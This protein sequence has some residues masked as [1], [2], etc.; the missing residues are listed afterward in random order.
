MEDVDKTF[1]VERKNKFK[2]PVVHSGNLLLI[3]NIL[4]SDLRRQTGPH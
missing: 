2:R 1:Q 4:L 3:S